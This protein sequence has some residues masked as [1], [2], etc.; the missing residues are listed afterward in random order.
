MSEE[1]IILKSVDGN[2]VA[3]AKPFQRAAV[4]C[5]AAGRVLRITSPSGAAKGFSK[6]RLVRTGKPVIAVQGAVLL[7]RSRKLRWYRAVFGF[8]RPLL[9]RGAFLFEKEETL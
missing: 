4:W 8:W 2:P 3:N 5:E 9:L 6:N 1:N 7:L